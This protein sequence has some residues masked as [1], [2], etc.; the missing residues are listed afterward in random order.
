MGCSGTPLL[1]SHDT[2]QH[3]LMIEKMF[4]LKLQGAQSATAAAAVSAE[5]RLVV[6]T[7]PPLAAFFARMGDKEHGANAEIRN[8][9]HGLADR[10]LGYDPQLRLTAQ[11][12]LQ[13]CP[14][15]S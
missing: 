8:G 14:F 11:E 10:L 4:G 13:E 3:L 9:L 15:L 2:A 1:P 5:D 6:D 12:A 7:T